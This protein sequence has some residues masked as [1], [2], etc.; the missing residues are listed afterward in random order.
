MGQEFEVTKMSSRGQIVIPQELREKMNLGE[1]S[2][3]A[4]IGMD[5]TIILKKL[6]PPKWEEFDKALSSLRKYGK[7][8]GIT[9]RK[10]DKAVRDTRRGG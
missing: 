2:K 9:E 7:E 4:I 6:K 1:G 10:V 5:D 8:K 3:F